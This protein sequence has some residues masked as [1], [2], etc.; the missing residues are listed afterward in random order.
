[1]DANQWMEFREQFGMSK[2][3]IADL[4]GVD[5]MLVE[6]FMNNELLPPRGQR[7][8]HELVLAHDKI[9]KLM[10]KLIVQRYPEKLKAAVAPVLEL[11]K[12]YPEGSVTRNFLNSQENWLKLF[13][14]PPQ[15]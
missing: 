14:E 3:D 7:G 11:A 1:M 15:K 4:A 8:P 5:V 6:K 9:F 10:L 12:T 2:Q 13:E